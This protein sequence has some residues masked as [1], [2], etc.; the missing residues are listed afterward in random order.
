[1]M[2]YSEARYNRFILFDTGDT[3]D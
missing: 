3:R 2:S 1:V